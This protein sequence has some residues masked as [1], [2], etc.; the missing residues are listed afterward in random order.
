MT[1]A[2]RTLRL[3]EKEAKVLSCIQLNAELSVAEVARMSKLTPATARRVISRLV[4]SRVIRKFWYLD[5]YALGN[6][7][8]NIWFTV[9]GV[10]AKSRQALEQYL[11]DS[12][13][14]VFFTETAGRFNYCATVQTATLTDFI[15]LQKEL[16]AHFGACFH[17][18]SVAT[19][20]SLTDLRLIKKPVV[21]S[22]VSSYRIGVESKKCV[23]SPL[24]EKLLSMLSK[25]PDAS[26][27]ALAR[28]LGE[29]ASTVDYRFKHLKRS[30]VIVGCRYF[31]DYLR[32]GGSI[33]YHQ[34]SLAGIAAGRYSEFIKFLECHPLVYFVEECLGPWDL[35]VGTFFSSID[36]HAG[37]SRELLERFESSVASIESAVIC[38]FIKLNGS[39]Y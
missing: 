38:R 23:L 33:A 26:L 19:I 10:H 35:E 34:I 2:A 11:I 7:L 36:Q 32:L 4:D 9:S 39:T 13:A 37:F 14:V 22:S 6:T 29:S 20:V 18:K 21:P 25:S 3:S 27:S 17:E 1:L 5:A 28:E 31:V 30:G 24:D 16:A 8:F 15:A 12:R